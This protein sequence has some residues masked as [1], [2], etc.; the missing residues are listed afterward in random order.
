MIEIPVQKVDKK[1]E[2]DHREKMLSF[3][4]KLFEGKTLNLGQE[5]SS[6]SLTIAKDPNTF[7]LSDVFSV[8][9]TLSS[10][11]KKDK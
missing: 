5:Q 8:A 11:V 9:E 6:S 1:E 3:A 7:F 2:I 10:Y 4:I